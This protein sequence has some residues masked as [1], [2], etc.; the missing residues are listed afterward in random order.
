LPL[1]LAGLGHEAALILP[2]YRQAR[3]AGVPVVR[4][5]EKLRI[6]IASRQVEGEIL[7]S[8]LPGSEVPVYLIDQPDYYDRDELYRRG[9]EDY[10][11][12]CER[13]V[14]FS[15]AVLETI[16]L[17]Q[18]EIDCIH[19]ND[20]QTGLVPA[21]LQIEY[22][23]RDGFEHLGT[24]FTVHNLGYHG[25]FWHWDM[26]LTGLDWKYFNWQ[27][28]EFFGHLNLL[29][30]GLVFA[31]ILSTVSPRYAQ[32]IQ[33][34]QFGHGLEGVLT[35]RRKDL[36]GIINGIDYEVWNP[37]TDGY[38]AAN[39]HEDTVSVGKP[40]C[41]AELQERCKLPMRAGVPVIG[42]I[43]RLADQKGLDLVAQAAPEW[44]KEDLQLVVLG[45][46]EPK[47]H[48][49]LGELAAQHPEKV[50]LHLTFDDALAHQIEAGA[51]MFLMPSRYEPCGLNQL[52]SL[53]YG[54]VPVVRAVGGLADTIVDATPAGLAAG[55]ANGFS[56]SEYT[57]EALLRTLRRALAAYRQ[58]EMWRRL[59]QT[60]MQQDWS[61]R[62]SAREYAALYERALAEH[63][64]P[65]C[66]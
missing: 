44:I 7:R 14:F 9:G 49:L 57:S 46:G 33:T 29:K 60:G 31:D 24:V 35:A 47:Y 39:Y 6:P 11:D 28:M 2:F 54:T 63:A 20:W 38:L 1:A 40:K 43:T 34:P 25:Q 61:W 41:K 23:Q 13:F 27:Q 26:L 8:H 64:E 52:Y 18:L 32:E 12:N 58:R 50:S 48:Q 56:F 53:K 5:G 51:D 21:Y 65:V 45:T 17:L 36:Y 15:R 55:E 62:R 22:R 59:M 3:K 42:M 16:R 66:V 4:T 30:T 37:A 19:A 10:K